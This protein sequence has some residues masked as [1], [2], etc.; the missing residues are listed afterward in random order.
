MKRIAWF[1]WAC[2]LCLGCGE[3]AAP[4]ERA[5]EAPR[6]LPVQEELK[7]TERSLADPLTAEEVRSFIALVKSLPDGQPP[8]FTPVSTGAKVQ[9]LHLDEAIPAWREAVRQAL[10]VE[11]L[12]N[13]WTPKSTVRRA[14]VERDVDRKSTRLNSSHGHQSRMPS[15]A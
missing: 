7:I 13:S 6:V 8:T 15:S 10:T 14:L 5:V 3:T 1:L 12:L 4:P 2:A 11:S 9:G